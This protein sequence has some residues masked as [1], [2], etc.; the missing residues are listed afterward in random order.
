MYSQLYS[1]LNNISNNE[2]ESIIV[3]KK[4]PNNFHPTSAMLLGDGIK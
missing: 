4:T 1:G 3:D 2:F